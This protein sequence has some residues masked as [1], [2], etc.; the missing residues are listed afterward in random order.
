[1]PSSRFFQRI[2]IGM[3]KEDPG[4]GLFLQGPLLEKNITDLPVFLID[5]SG[6]GLRRAPSSQGHGPGKYAETHFDLSYPAMTRFPPPMGKDLDFRF[7]SWG[8]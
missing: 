7:K 6:D 4:S 5:W 3:Q 2:V 1:M 8:E